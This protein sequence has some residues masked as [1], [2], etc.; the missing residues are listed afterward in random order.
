MAKEQENL[1][2]L[3]NLAFSSTKRKSKS[4]H[5]ETQENILR[6]MAVSADVLEDDLK[7]IG[8]GKDYDSILELLLR[9]QTKGIE[10]FSVPVIYKGTI[11]SEEYDFHMPHHI[12]WATD[13]YR[14]RGEGYQIADEIDVSAITGRKKRI[15]RP[16]AIKSKEEQRRRI[17][18]K[19]EVFTPSWVCNAQNNL[20]DEAWFGCKDVFNHE[21]TDQTWTT[22]PK[23]IRFPKSQGRTWLD[24]VNERRLELCCGEGPYIVSRYDAT[25]GELI[26]IRERIGLLDRKLRVVRENI[27]PRK[28][29]SL[30]ENMRRWREGAYKA[31]RSIYGFEWQGDNLLLARENILVSFIEYFYDYCEEYHLDAQLKT[32]TLAHVAY[33]ISWNIWQMDGLKYIIPYS[34]QNI[35]RQN[36]LNFEP[37]SKHLPENKDGIYA[38]IAH[39]TGKG[40]EKYHQTFEFRDLI[41]NK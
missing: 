32:S 21:N 19:A 5:K 22:N 33:I 30:D 31:I 8:Q 18:Q 24:Y 17:K 16:R 14:L 2:N 26:P 7:K 11:L 15:I 37:D 9:D 12:I 13:N 27:K 38:K 1:F 28:D 35:V 40:R 4:Q 6:R 34:D 39:W 29:L 41:N 20:I 23:R 36:E 10:R 25:T 3:E